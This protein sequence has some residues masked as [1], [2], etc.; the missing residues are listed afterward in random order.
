[1]SETSTLELS[2]D[3]DPLGPY[4]DFLH[5][6]MEA[7]YELSLADRRE[8]LERV[9]DLCP[10][11]ED[12]SV[13]STLVDGI[14]TWVLTPPNVDKAAPRS[15]LYLH[16]G[17]FLSGSFVSHGGLACEIAVASSAVVFFPEYRLAPEHPFPAAFDDVLTVYNSLMG[18]G[19]TTGVVSA[20]RLG[21]CGDSAGATLLVALVQ[22]LEDEGRKKPAA[23]VAISPALDLSC[24]SPS[25]ERNADK[26]IFLSREPL[27]EDLA[28][29]TNGHDLRDPR[30]SP[31][32]GNHEN[33]P[34]VLLQVGAS[35]ICLDDSRIFADRIIESGGTARLEV[36]ARVQ[37]VWHLFAKMVPQSRIAISSIGN[38]F[39]SYL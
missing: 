13:T 17:A 23:C 9:R 25:Y 32:F 39:D 29:Y 21:I 16:G 35:E 14:T 33:F 11:R 24:S 37:H 1:M 15:I 3:S 10:L 26:D 30:I 4:L 36:Y 7:R 28:L 8:R 6:S 18:E 20:D 27:L 34:P 31:L 22:Y 5:S 2:V 19:V 12:V 38:F